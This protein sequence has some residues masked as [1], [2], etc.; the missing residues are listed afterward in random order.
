MN[1]M[2]EIKNAEKL[3][4]NCNFDCQR[5]KAKRILEK[6]YFVVDI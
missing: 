1:Q 4:I 6:I 3:P 2:N 5:W